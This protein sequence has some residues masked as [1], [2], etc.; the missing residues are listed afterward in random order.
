V[1]FVD[2]V[3]AAAIGALAG[4]VVILGQRTI[5]GASSSPDLVKLA[6]LLLALAVLVRFQKLP[7]PLLIF[8]AGLTGLAI[9]PLMVG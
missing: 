2:G 3:T 4:A 9:H 1:A 7:E 6:T 5:F 8:A